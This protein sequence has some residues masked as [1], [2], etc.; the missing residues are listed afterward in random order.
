MPPTRQVKNMDEEARRTNNKRLRAVHGGHRGVITKLITETNEILATTPLTT[1]GRSR[2]D[3]IH[4]QLG[5]KA[6]LRGLDN[7]ILA[8]CEV[9]DID[10]E[11][12]EA[13]PIT[14]EVIEYKSKIAK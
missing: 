7:D 3:V 5:L 10:T 11:I 14:A 13:E 9:S 6:E 2:L 4:K 8:L 1:E 12:E